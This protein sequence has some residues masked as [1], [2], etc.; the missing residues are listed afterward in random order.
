MAIEIKVLGDRDV[1]ILTNVAAGVFDDPID[2]ARAEEFLLDR[3]HH[4]VVAVAEGTVVGFASAVHYLHPDK[5]R[6][7]LWINEIGVAGTHRR[8]GIGKRLLL[9]MLEVGRAAGCVEAWVLTDPKN[10]AA[11]QLYSRLGNEA[12]ADQLMFTFQ[13]DE[14][15]I[16]L[17]RSV[18]S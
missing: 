13:L 15:N 5:Q 10:M 12:P 14:R 6:P 1:R 3:R 18:V 9:S 2:L 16:A 8:R 7:E 11:R 17:P 4:L